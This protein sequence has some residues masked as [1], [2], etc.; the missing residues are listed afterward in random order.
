MMPAHRP[1]APTPAGDSTSTPSGRRRTLS[2]PGASALLDPGIDFIKAKRVAAQ[3]EYVEYTL[4]EEELAQL[5]RMGF[6]KLPLRIDPYSAHVFDLGIA[7]NYFCGVVQISTSMIYLCPLVPALGGPPYPASLVVYSKEGVKADPI[8]HTSV[9]QRSQGGSGKASHL[10]FADRLGIH[11]ADAIGFTL[12]KMPSGAGRIHSFT[13]RSLHANTMSELARYSK[14]AKEESQQLFLAAFAKR[15][16]GTPGGAPGG[17]NEHGR[18]TEEWA[19]RIA[20]T[21][22]VF[23]HPG[24]ARSGSA[25]PSRPP[26]P[27]PPWSGSGGQASAPGT[28]AA[29]ARIDPTST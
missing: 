9:Q 28:P 5:C 16:R 7:D 17:L 19:I 2:D 14:A 21:I 20:V 4:S 13:S 11:C 8:E 6:A 22:T 18:L 24:R 26:R 1:P 29:A 27:V 15:A 3:P 23:F 12:V 25:P 10:T